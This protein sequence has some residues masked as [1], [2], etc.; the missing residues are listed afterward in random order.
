MKVGIDSYCYHR[1]FGE[2]YSD[3]KV[4]TN[5]MTLQDFLIRAKELRVD[6][7]SLE[8]CFFPKFDKGWLNELGDQIKEYNFD[9]VYAWGH[10]LG[11]E[12]GKNIDAFKDMIE[13]IPR[14]KAIGAKVMRVVGSSRKFRNEPHAPQIRALIQ[15]FK[16]AIKAA[17]YYDLRIAV[18]NHIDYNADEILQIIEGVGS[19]YLG[20][21]FDTGNFL[22]LLDDPIRGMEML[23]PYVAATHVKDLLPDRNVSP[24]EWYYFAGVPIGEGL[25]DNKKLAKLLQKENFTGFL[26]VEIDHPHSEWL[27][28]EDEAVV[29]SISELKKIVTNIESNR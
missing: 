29:K 26:A 12:R 19:E 8:S 23:A 1:F 6:G 27:G 7:V 21:N 11:L 18:E 3:Q 15:M 2:I 22:R 4:P 5:R 16:E 13:S 25:I 17:E 14:A 20:V 9:V 28:R 10:P 24:N